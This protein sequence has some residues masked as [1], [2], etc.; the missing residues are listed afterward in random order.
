MENL[1]LNNFEHSREKIEI[2][3][4]G[5]A[6]SVAPGST[7]CPHEGAI[8]KVRYMAPELVSGSG[9]YDPFKADVFAL[10]VCLFSVLIGQMPFS[11]INDGRANILQDSAAKLIAFIDQRNVE[12]NNCGVSEECID[13]L[14]KCLKWNPSERLTMEQVLNHRFFSSGTR[15]M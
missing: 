2:I 13:L 11:K 9:E 15:K 10:G 4:W 14:N 1:V 5:H 12:G 8:G 6:V 3:D 7:R